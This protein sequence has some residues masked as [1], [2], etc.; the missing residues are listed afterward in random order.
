MTDPRTDVVEAARIRAL[1]AG[2]L[3]AP[4]AF[5]LNLELGYL[6]VRPSCPRDDA[7]PLHL[8]HAASL[9]LALAGMF[10]AWRCWRA[11]GTRWPDQEGGPEARS[12]F[13]A[14]LGV[15]LSALFVLALVAQWIPTFT[16][17]PCQ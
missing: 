4:A 10:T 15:M 5:F 2:L 9:V 12:Q 7:L 11:E 16:L 17:H 6:L 8:V 13:M 3:L 1:W 14:G